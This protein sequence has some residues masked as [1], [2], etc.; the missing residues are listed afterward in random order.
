MFSRESLRVC[1][2]G[3]VRGGEMR[4]SSTWD[5]RLLFA[6]AVVAWLIRLSRSEDLLRLCRDVKLSSRGFISGGSLDILRKV[7][8]RYIDI[9]NE[10]KCRLPPTTLIR[11]VEYVILVVASSPPKRVVQWAVALTGSMYSVREI[12]AVKTR[13]GINPTSI[14]AAKSM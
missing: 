10:T 7:T 14:M 11:N 6:V 4:G 2:N 5:S 3:T 1:M 12:R 9:I 13:N 8:P